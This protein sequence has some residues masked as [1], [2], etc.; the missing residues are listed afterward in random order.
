MN[1][2]KTFKGEIIH[3]FGR[4]HRTVGYATAN[5]STD[6][7]ELDIP[8]S[9]FGVYCGL[10]YILDKSAHI[11]VVSIGKNLTFNHNKPTFE[12][13]IL[14]FNEDIYGVLMTIDLKNYIRPMMKFNSF[15]ELSAQI[16]LDSQKSRELMTPFLN[17]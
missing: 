11:G 15:Q 13:H 17:S 5:I 9:D 16:T 4:G 12:V 2:P 1:L 3:G 6:G 7:W 14:D 10:V 8:E